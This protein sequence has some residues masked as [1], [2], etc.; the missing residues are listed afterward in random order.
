[1]PVAGLGQR[2][3]IAHT[4]QS[5]ICS[6]EHGRALFA[7]FFTMFVFTT[8]YSYRVSCA[9]YL[10][11][12]ISALLSKIAGCQALN[13]RSAVSKAA[14]RPPHIALHASPQREMEGP[15]D[16][17][18]MGAAFHLPQLPPGGPRSMAELCLPC[19]RGMV[20]TTAIA[21]KELCCSSTTLN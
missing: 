17:G 4:K 14:A 8:A 19:W 2:L 5:C 6:R 18:S 20:A 12:S 7:Q 16:S 15:A 3:A 11:R 9:A 21:G 1:M 13:A 10:T